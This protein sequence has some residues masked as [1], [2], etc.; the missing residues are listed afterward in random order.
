MTLWESISGSLQVELTSAEGQ[1][2]LKTVNQ[3][4][5]SVFRLEQTDDLTAKFWIRRRDLPKL[6][7]LCEKQGDRLTVIG[8]RGVYWAGVALLHRPVLL[9]G[10]ALLMALGMYLP[11]RVL[12]I[13]VEGNDKIPAR[14]ILWAAE[15]CGVGFGASRRY[16]RSEKVK[17][18]LLEAIPELGWA[19]VN[20]SGCTAVISVRERTASREAATPFVPSA[21]VAGRDGFILSSNVTQGT[22]LFQRG[23]TVRKGQTLISG[24]T[25]CGICIRATGA[26]GEVYAQTRRD[27]RAVTPDTCT[28]RRKEQAV[29][30]KYSLRYRKKRINLWKDSGIC[31]ATCGRMYKEYH[32]TLPGGFRLPM[33]LCVEEYTCWSSEPAAV[34]QAQAEAALKTFAES[35]LREQMISGE[36]LSKQESLSQKEG[37]FFLEGTYDCTE[38]IGRAEKIGETNGKRD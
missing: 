10:L 4:Q 37:G 16:V 25:D 35:Y 8:R 11:S 2:T 12:F 38:M 29:R 24:F 19:G 3:Q 26:K 34:D 31:D 6:Q 20:T 1:R 7:K 28:L 13:R 21:I 27:L 30:R 33:A 14:Q 15:D 17:N 23:Q 22:A 5:I 18:A 36:I 32:I 9:A